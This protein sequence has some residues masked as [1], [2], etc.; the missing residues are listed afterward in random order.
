MQAINE[1]LITLFIKGLR[2]MDASVKIFSGRATLP[3]AKEIAKC[4][5]LSLGN[6]IISKFSD[7]EFI[8]SFEETVRG[9]KVF[10]VNRPHHPQII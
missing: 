10:I 1:W 4:Y 8:P 5:G 7:G 6:I 9:S 3:L 2:N